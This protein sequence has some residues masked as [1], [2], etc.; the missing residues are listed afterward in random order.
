MNLACMLHTDVIHHF[1]RKKLIPE[2]ICEKDSWP[3]QIAGPLQ[4]SGGSGGGGVADV[5]SRL[6]G[7]VGL[8]EEAGALSRPRHAHRLDAATGGLLLV[9]KTADALRSLSTAFEDRCGLPNTH[10][11]RSAWKRN[12]PQGVSSAP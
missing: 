8:S 7:S 6:L 2:D 12:P 11:M 1:R 3:T 4:S 5:H 9:A 10:P